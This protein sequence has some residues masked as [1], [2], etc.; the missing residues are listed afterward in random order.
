M[1]SGDTR[2]WVGNHMAVSD[3]S[4]ENH[5]S[6]TRFINLLVQWHSAC[7]ACLT[8]VTGG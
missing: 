6:M 5:A 3:D 1:E 4:N 8:A 7:S 2:T